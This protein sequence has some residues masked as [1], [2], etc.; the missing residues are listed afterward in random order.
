MKDYQTETTTTNSFH[1]KYRRRKMT[2][3]HISSL[4]L[5]SLLFI[6]FH[7]RATLGFAPKTSHRFNSLV[8]V[9]NK[10]HQ[11]ASQRSDDEQQSRPAPFF[12][13]E[14][15]EEEQQQ[16]QQ[17]ATNASWNTVQQSNG[18]T[19][20]QMQEDYS[21]YS[22]TNNNGQ[23]QNL[24]D[25]YYQESSQP[26]ATAQEQQQPSA[27]PNYSSPQ[28]DDTGGIS[29]VDARVLESILADGK[30]DL[31]SEEEVKK[32]LEGPRKTEEFFAPSNNSEQEESGKYSSK[33]ISVSSSFLCA[34]FVTL[35]T[36]H[37]ISLSVTSTINLLLLRS[38]PVCLR[39]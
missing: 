16:Q 1:Y 36:N 20:Q 38:P 18:Y 15:F 4:S 9:S 27:E 10:R 3:P 21:G 7:L 31:N 22:E 35:F 8:S 34:F 23:Y 28:D 5:L 39:Q 33:V 19:Q 26:Q 37:V 32:L 17:D 13:M 25:Y 24:Q 2:T 11:L 6:T 12:I 30:L 14:N 29:N